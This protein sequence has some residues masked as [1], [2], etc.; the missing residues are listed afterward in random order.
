[1]AGHHDTII[2]TGSTGFIGATLIN[3]FAGPFALI[4]LDRATAALYSD[5]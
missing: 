1:M 3:M 2:V 5:Q 4:G